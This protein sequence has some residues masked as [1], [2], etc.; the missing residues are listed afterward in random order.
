M[1]DLEKLIAAWS[2][3]MR[4]EMSADQIAEVEDHL[5]ERISDFLRQQLTVREA[6]DKA[7]AELG[8]GHAVAAEFQKL[9]LKWWWPLKL[10]FAFEVAAFVCGLLLWIRLSDRQFGFLLGAHV[11]AITVGYV[12]ALIIGLLGVAF[13]AQRTMADFPSHKAERIAAQLANF[14]IFAFIA[15]LIGLILAAAWAK[16]AWGHMTLT[17]AKS[18]GA[19][20][21]LVSTLCLVSAHRFRV[22]S[23]L[24]IIK[25]AILIGIVVSF[26]WLGANSWSV[27]KNLYSWPL[28]IITFPHA[29]A[30]AVSF[31]PAGWA[32]GHRAN[33]A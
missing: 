12:A 17:D 23:P 16:A 1:H 31:A 7:L 29:L 18:F 30:L 4:A 9:N 10:G 26:A 22:V 2:R 3:S 24:G 11:F 21:T 13:V 33:A 28:W 20:A 19:M 5:R 14:S 6:F 15:T 8:S 27:G 25:L 32:A